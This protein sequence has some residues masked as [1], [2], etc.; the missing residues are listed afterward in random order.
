MYREFT[1]RKFTRRIY[2]ANAFGQKLCSTRMVAVLP[3]RHRSRSEAAMG[4]EDER[5]SFQISRERL[6]AFRKISRHHEYETGKGIRLAYCVASSG[7]RTYSRGFRSCLLY[8]ISPRTHAR[9][10]GRALFP[11][12]CEHFRS[13]REMVSRLCDGWCVTRSR[14]VVSV[15]AAGMGSAHCVDRNRGPSRLLSQERSRSEKDRR[16]IHRTKRP[17]TVGTITTISSQ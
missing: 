6:G 1:A 3:T 17:R 5:P 10:H 8:R 4:L 11:L 13:D 2:R 14:R 16:F 7:G 15:S 9:V 12:R